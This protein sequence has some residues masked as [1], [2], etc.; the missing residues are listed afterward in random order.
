MNEA[1]DYNKLASAIAER[2]TPRVP[3]DRQLWDSEMCAE[4]FRM[5]VSNFMQSIACNPSF[6]KAIRVPSMRGKSSLPRWKAKEV[7]GWTEGYQR[8]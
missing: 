6:P 8:D 4:Y 2:L 7:I 1:I 5:S 3:F